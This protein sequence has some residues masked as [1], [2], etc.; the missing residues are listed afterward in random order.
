MPKDQPARDREIDRHCSQSLQIQIVRRKI[1]NVP[2][3]LITL[4]LQL[5][6]ESEA[7]GSA[8]ELR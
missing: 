1:S 3:E 2:N 5:D 7:C 8:D 4:L 6:K